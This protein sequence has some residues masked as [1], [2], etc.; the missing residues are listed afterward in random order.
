VDETVKLYGGID[1]LINNAALSASGTGPSQL[2]A[3]DG[4]KTQTSH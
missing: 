1:I 2:L 3:V 4:G